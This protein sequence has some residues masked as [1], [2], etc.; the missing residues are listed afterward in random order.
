MVHYEQWRQDYGELF[1]AVQRSFEPA[2]VAL[3]S[4]GTLTFTKPVMRQIRTRQL[5]SKILQMPLVEADG[6]L[7][8]PEEIKLDMFRHAY[9]ELQSWHDK[10]FFYLCMENHRLWKPVFRYEY[11]SNEAFEAAM[12]SSYMGKDPAGSRVLR[13]QYGSATCATIEALDLSHVARHVS[14]CLSR[15][16]KLAR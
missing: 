16:T 3:V 13:R 1:E 6:K 15:I 10:V 2:E 9:R 12:K 5:K 7:S 4:L 14:P 8:Y 11:P